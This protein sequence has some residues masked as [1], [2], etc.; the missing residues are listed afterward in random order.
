LAAGKGAIVPKTKDDALAAVHAMMVDR[1]FGSA[2]DEVI[3]EEFMEGEEASLFVISDG[4]N[5]RTFVPAQDHKPVFDGD[6]GPNTG[7]MGAYAP[8]PVMTPELVSDVCERIVQPTLDAMRCDGSEYKGILYVG[9]MMTSEGPKVVEMNSRWGDPEAQIV[10]PLLETDMLG[11]M[12]AA[13]DGTLDAIDIEERDDAA[14]IVMLASSGYPDAYQKGF[15]ISGLDAAAKRPGVVVF[16]SGTAL[17]NGEYVTNG[18]RVLGV[19]AVA[20]GI[21][22]AIHRAYDAVGDIHFEGMHYRRDIGHRAL[23]RLSN[24]GT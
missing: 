10:L 13:I 21:E 24:K 6:T 1:A 7:G 11:L 4:R 23:K 18:G 3:V 17:R 2:G 16:H 22:S 20:P 8:A 19:T 5:Y 9:L 14:V 15:P 12:D